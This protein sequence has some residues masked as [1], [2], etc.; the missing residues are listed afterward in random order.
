MLYGQREHFVKTNI[1]GSGLVKQTADK[2]IEILNTP[3]TKLYN[4]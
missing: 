3:I 1:Y 2:A 4:L